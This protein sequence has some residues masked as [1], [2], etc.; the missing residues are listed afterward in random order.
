MNIFGKIGFFKVIFHLLLQRYVLSDENQGGSKFE[1]STIRNIFLALI[2]FGHH[3]MA[4]YFLSKDFQ[5]ETF[6][7]RCCFISEKQQKF[8]T[9]KCRH[10]VTH[11]V[12]KPLD[13]VSLKCYD[14]KCSL[15]LWRVVR[16][17]KLMHLDLIHGLFIS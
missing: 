5:V 1:K 6:F 3:S 2:K 7:C 17:S 12:K 11:I 13:R 14:Y 16:G 4:N 10:F 15:S 8:G 9:K